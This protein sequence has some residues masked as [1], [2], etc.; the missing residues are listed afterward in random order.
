MTGA[1]DPAI[2]SPEAEELERYWIQV[3]IEQ[4]MEDSMTAEEYSY[5]YG[6]VID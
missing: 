1:E 3:Q 6:S 5:W 2:Q 4:E